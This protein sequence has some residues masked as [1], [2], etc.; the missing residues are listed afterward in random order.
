RQLGFVRFGG[1]RLFRFLLEIRRGRQVAVGNCDGRLR[2]RRRRG[3]RH[4]RSVRG[5][6][7]RHTMRFRARWLFVTPN[8]GARREEQNHDRDRFHCPPPFGSPFRSAVLVLAVSAPPACSL[9][10]F[11]YRTFSLSRSFAT[12]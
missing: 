2:R 1:N 7:R 8:E 12:R 11:W 9:I 6:G 10:H 4:R 3:C 5:G